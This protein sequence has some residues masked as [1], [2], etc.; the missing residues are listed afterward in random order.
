VKVDVSYPASGPVDA[1]QVAQS[2]ESSGFA[3]LWVSEIK[4]DPFVAS[5]LAAV[6]T[7]RLEVGTGVAL[8][9]ARSPMTVAVQAH[10][11][12]SL[13]EGRFVLGLG[14]QVKAHITR[15]FGMPWS[16]PA[17]RMR[18]FVTALRAIWDCWDHGIALSFDGDFYT[19]TLM[20]VQFVPEPHLFGPPPVFLA[21]V[22]EVMTEVA[23]EVADGFLC[24]GFTTERYLREVTL[25]ALER[26]RAHKG[27]A[28]SGF[29]VSGLPFV[30]TGATEESFAAARAAVRAQIAFYGSTP[31]YRGVLE[32]HGWADLGGALHKLSVEGRWTELPA[33]VDDEV[34]R[35]FAVVEEPA[36]VAS[37]LLRRYGDLMTR[38]TF[39]TP[40]DLEPSVAAGIASEVTSGSM[41]AGG[42]GERP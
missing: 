2:T 29:Q 14:S 27:E 28:L 23:G 5:A 35:A 38:M 9:F 12:Q 30:V 8:A 13:S 41:A 25:P 33:L 26:G 36:G 17:A 3:G 37:E 4:R 21:G 31:A 6:A 1:R 18:E 11:L 10:E 34:L 15:R 22:G 16:R 42:R 7:T 32:L 40:Y 24:H 20:P 19:H 39:Y